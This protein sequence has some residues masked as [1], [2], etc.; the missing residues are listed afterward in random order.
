MEKY[1]FSGWATR[2]DLVCSD[3]RTIRK[4]AFKHCDGKT[5]PLVWNH[6]HSDPDNVLGHALLENRNEGV[7]AYCSFNNTENAKNI[8]EAV[9][10]GDVRSLSIFANQLKQAGSD[11]IHGAIREVSLVLAG[12]NP[13][14]FIDSVMAHGDGVETGIILGYDEN[15]MLYHSEDA[16]D[17]SDKKEES[18]KSEEKEETIA[19]VF[20]TL[21]EKQK[22]VVYAMIGQAIEDADNEEDSKDDSEG[23]NDT[24][25]HNVFEPEVN[26]DTNVLSHSDQA[27]IIA[28]A[29]SSSVGTLK[30]AIGIYLENNKDT[31]A[32][33]IESIET[34]FPE[35]KDVRPGA[36]E[37]LTTDQG[38]IGKVLAK[39]HK[40]P[41]SRIR[42]RQADIRNIEALRAQ[43][44]KKGSEKKYVGNFSLIH[45]TTD[46]QTVYVKSKIDRD[47]IIDIQDFDV[48]QYLYGIDRMNLNEELATAI[49]LGDG[50]EDGDEGKIAQ[51]KIRPIW[52]DDELYTI[53]ADVDIAGMKTSL[54]GTNT[55][56][57]FGDNY[58]YAEAV[59]QSLLYA[60][61][62]Y[63]GSGTP[64]FYCTPHLLNVMLLARD[65]NGRRIYDNVNELRAALNVGEIITA[66]QF[67]GKVRTTKDQKK[68]K[69]LP[70][71]AF[72]E[73]I[74][75]VLSSII[76][77]NTEFYD[78]ARDMVAG[79]ANG[80]SANTFLAEAKAAEMAAAAARAARREL[81]EHS[82]SKV[83]YEIGDFFGVAFVGA[84]GDYADKSYRAGAEMGSKARI[85]LTE[86]VSKIS[87]Y[88]N[89]DIDAQPTIR[90]VLD[91]SNV[92]SGTRQINAMFSRT[93]AMSI[94]A[95]MSRAHT[96]GNQN[97]GFQDGSAATY[98]Y[99]TQNNYSPKAL[100]RVE[101]Y[102]QTK[103]QFS[104]MKGTVS[105]R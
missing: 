16:A 8:K 100:S 23:G 22:T 67:E 6:N 96:S 57:N 82:P 95:N 45:R 47:D 27:S 5:V 49:V 89:S 32:H 70:I 1:D 42:T 19:D 91:L 74:T 25:K 99:F 64:D 39:V 59:I 93:Q 24:M 77:R 4:D 104:A 102:R 18:A 56:A 94:N 86:A 92:Q 28:L 55:G 40:S 61:E 84:I 43:G 52:L 78:A 2:N 73:I 26:E 79:F 60:R 35:Y 46:P 81:D 76:V 33:G 20:D 71:V 62:K 30:D 17:T 31:L 9:R 85:G 48:V 51:D 13:G 7:Y 38:W 90:P 10:H 36:P 37:L 97:G 68:K 87:D 105:K 50:R 88:I 54:Q 15:I 12:A 63:K 65:L 3:G 29:K 66:E 41:I 58:V 101:I 53:H 75:D 98:N 72:G 69:L 80:I 14:A 11:V 83:G 21:S 44:Y 34:L 103:N